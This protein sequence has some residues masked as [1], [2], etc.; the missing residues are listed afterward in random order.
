MNPC[1]L[2][3]EIVNYPVQGKEQYYSYE[4]NIDYKLFESSGRYLY[5]KLEFNDM[6]VYVTA[7]NKLLT[8]EECQFL[9]SFF[10]N[11]DFII[12]DC[13]GNLTAELSLPMQIYTNVYPG[14]YD[15][16]LMQP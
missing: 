12:T 4:S 9:M 11:F 6:N 3:K 14:H 10:K 2:I 5:V 8:D 7:D 1:P 15:R 16:V 13:K